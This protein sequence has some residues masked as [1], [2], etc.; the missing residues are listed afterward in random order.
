MRKIPCPKA[1]LW[2]RTVKKSLIYCLEW[3]VKLPEEMTE[4]PQMVRTLPSK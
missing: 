3:E 2:A 1:W 4:Q